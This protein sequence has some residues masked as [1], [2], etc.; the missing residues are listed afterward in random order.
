MSIRRDHSVHAIRFNVLELACIAYFLTAWMLAGAQEKSQAPNAAKTGAEYSGMYSFLSEGEFVQISVE[1][2]GHVIGLISRY[3]DSAHE[4]GFVNDFFESG[5]LKGNQLSFTTKTVQGVS[6]A[7]R[8]T[9]ERGEG[10]SRSDEGYYVLK[11]TLVENTTDAAKKASSR[12]VEVEFKSFPQD[13]APP[14]P[15]K[16]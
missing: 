5:Q 15:G 7:F 8:G 2:E 13:L 11:G 6:F 14:E 1:D 4:G 10:K 12:S 16:K 3:A 9:V